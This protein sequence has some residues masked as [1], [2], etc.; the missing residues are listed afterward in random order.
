M[1]VLKEKMYSIGQ[2]CQINHI[3]RNRIDENKKKLFGLVTIFDRESY[4]CSCSKCIV[5]IRLKYSISCEFS[6][7]RPLSCLH[8]IDT[9]FNERIRREIRGE[10]I[11]QLWDLCRGYLKKYFYSIKGDLMTCFHRNVCK[12]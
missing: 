9:Y 7:G 5:E 4:F 3:I 12:Y 1:A 10:Y 11:F 2:G 6:G 8:Q